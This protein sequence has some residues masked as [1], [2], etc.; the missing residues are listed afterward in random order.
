[1]HG[2]DGGVEGCD[3]VG[4][5]REDEA[6]LL[7]LDGVA[8]DLEGVGVGADVAA[9]AGGIDEHHVHVTGDE[10]LD[11]S[12]EGLEELDAR[13]GLVAVED[14]VNRR[15]E[16]GGAGLRADQ[17][18]GVGGKLG[19]RREAVFV[20]AHEHELLRGHVGCAEVNLLRPFLGD[21]DA[22]HADVEL[23]GVDGGDHG[24]PRGVVPLHHAVEP[25]ADFRHC[26]VL[27]AH[28]LARRR[29]DELQRR[30]VVRH[31]RTYH[32]PSQIGQSVDDVGARR[33][34]RSSGNVSACFFP[35]C[36]FHG[37]CRFDAGRCSGRA[38]TDDQCDKQ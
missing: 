7:G 32:P 9:S 13:V 22:V 26:V 30:V 20:G 23:T 10:R 35:A 38:R 31:R 3:E 4:A 28:R 27:P 21:G 2:G 33:S 25:G 16:A 34:R 19:W 17:E 29:V 8:D 36:F 15:V 18:V 6:E 14:V 11:G 37:S 24:V 5:G 1:M 12:A